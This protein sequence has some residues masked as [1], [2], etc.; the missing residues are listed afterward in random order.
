MS[1][2]NREEAIKAT[3][4][5]LVEKVESE[6]ADFTN[7]VTDNGHTE[8]SASVRFEDEDGEGTLTMLVLIPDEE[9]DA[10]EELD[11]ID[12]DKHIAEAEYQVY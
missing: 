10:C 12:W 6:N 9:V 3:S 7:R 4:L 2:L 1:N 5:E 8:F 11:Q